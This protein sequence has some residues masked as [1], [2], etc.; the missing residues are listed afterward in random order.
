MCLIAYVPAGK[1]MPDDYVESAYR[2][3]DDGIGIMSEDGIRK[4]LGRKALKRARRYLRELHDDELEYAIHFRYATH[5]AV[6]QHNCHPHELPNGNG[7]LMHNGVL[8]DYTARSTARDSDNGVF[9]SELTHGDAS[10]ENW[11]A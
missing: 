7:W 1:Q 3:N 4:F 5:G 11:K 6:T 8:A 10:N 2:Q 9:G